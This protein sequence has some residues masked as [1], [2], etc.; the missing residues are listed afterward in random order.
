MAGRE[1]SNSG[2]F[3]QQGFH[4]NNRANLEGASG[5]RNQRSKKEPLHFKFLNEKD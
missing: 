5:Y 1:D 3:Q 4:G 2:I